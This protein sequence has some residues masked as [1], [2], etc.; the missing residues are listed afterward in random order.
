MGQSSRLLFTSS[1]FIPDI[2]MPLDEIEG[3]E[4]PNLGGLLRR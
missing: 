2:L 1:M 3:I 4:E